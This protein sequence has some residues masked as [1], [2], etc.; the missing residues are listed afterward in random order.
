M[1]ADVRL[2]ARS[3]SRTPVFTA[4]VV[5][6]LV[7]G[8][9]ANTTIFSLVDALLLRPLPVRDPQRLV[10][11]ITIRPPLLPYSEF[12][13]EEYEAWKKQGSGF[14]DVVA[15]SEHDMFVAAGETTE[16]ARIHF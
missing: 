3:L 14:Q 7:F 5:L 4:G 6:L 2:A 8:V 15:W 1:W 11:L 9:A 13:Y 16:R 12:V 10:R